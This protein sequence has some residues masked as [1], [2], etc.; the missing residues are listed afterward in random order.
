MGES[1]DPDRREF[2]RVCVVGGAAIVGAGIGAWSVMA[3][4]HAA[5]APQ[6]VPLAPVLR[7][8]GLEKGKPL[9]LQVTLSR[10]DGWRLRTRGQHLFV[11]R[12]GDGETASDFKALSPVCPH[13]G[14][15]VEANEKDSAFVCPCHDGKFN[16]DGGYK[17][18]PA[19]RGLDPLVLSAGK[20]E[21][22]DWIFVNWQDFVIG[23]ADRTPRTA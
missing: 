9:A 11:V 4:A 1:A 3:P 19:P 20:H 15:S 21:G 13:K 17:S 10:R 14:C 23:T 12:T 2:L 7:L 16:L 18:G 5:S 22:A 6:T 8:T